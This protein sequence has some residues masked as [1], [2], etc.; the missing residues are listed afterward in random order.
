MTGLCLWTMFG[1]VRFKFGVC[2]GEWL[3]VS[4]FTFVVIWHLFSRDFF[5]VS[6]SSQQVFGRRCF[7]LVSVAPGRKRISFVRRCFIRSQ[8]F[9]IG[10]ICSWPQVLFFL[11]R[12][13]FCS[14]ASVCVGFSYSWPQALFP[15]P[16][17]F[18]FRPQVFFV[19]RVVPG[20]KYFSFFRRCYC[21]AGVLSFCFS[22]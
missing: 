5:V 11:F 17:A 7:R 15:L 21:S 18:S 6:L 20:R 19:V 1:G 13:C 14:A 12:G 22:W 8:V 10:F 9:S 3:H 16:Q 2:V 4:K